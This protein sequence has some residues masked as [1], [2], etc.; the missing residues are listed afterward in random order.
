MKKLLLKIV[1][2]KRIKFDNSEPEH[3]NEKM[4]DWAAQDSLT[5]GGFAIPPVLLKVGEESDPFYQILSG[6]FQCCAARI[7]QGIDPLKRE[8]IPAIVISDDD[9]NLKTFVHQMDNCNF[10]TIR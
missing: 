2:I 9:P 7:A 1:Q 10:Y 5:I 3:F 6:N 8:A 4:L